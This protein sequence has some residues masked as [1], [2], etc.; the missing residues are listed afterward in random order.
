VLE[1]TPDL[2]KYKNWNNQAGPI[3]SVKKPEIFMIKYKNGSKDLFDIP[4]SANIN[5]AQNSNNPSIM[6]NIPISNAVFELA[7][8]DQLIEQ[9]KKKIDS[10]LQSKRKTASDTMSIPK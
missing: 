4:V 9:I 7:K 2:V 6:I 8:N 3:Y 1:I 10:L 5:S